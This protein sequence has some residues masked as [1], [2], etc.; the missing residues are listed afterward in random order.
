VFV[1]Q[2]IER[3]KQP[4]P[5]N[6]VGPLMDLYFALTSES[7]TWTLEEMRDWLRKGGFTLRRSVKLRTSPGMVQ[8]IGLKP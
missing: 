2:D 1:L 5:K 8:A 7:G 4:S 3:G 6:Q